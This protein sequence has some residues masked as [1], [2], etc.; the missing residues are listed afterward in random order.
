MFDWFGSL[1]FTLLFDAWLPYIIGLVVGIILG[2]CWRDL[3]AAEASEHAT[4]G[5][6]YDAC[7]DEPPDHN[8][9]ARRLLN[10]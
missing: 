3:R 5:A 1:L 8:A 10:Y 6:A 9:V 4:S 2:V 7:E